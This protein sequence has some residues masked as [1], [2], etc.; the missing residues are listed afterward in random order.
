MCGIFSYPG[1]FPDA[2]LVVGGARW[3]RRRAVSSLDADAPEADEGSSE[4]VTPSCDPR[5]V[6]VASRRNPAHYAGRCC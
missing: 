4:E 2:V 1:W 6:A 3:P 5:Q